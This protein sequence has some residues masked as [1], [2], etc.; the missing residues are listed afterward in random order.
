MAFRFGITQEVGT[1]LGMFCP[2]P[3]PLSVVVRLSIEVPAGGA[4]IVSFWLTRR[5]SN[6]SNRYFL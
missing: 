3:K 5:N 6:V 2:R 1:P 4:K